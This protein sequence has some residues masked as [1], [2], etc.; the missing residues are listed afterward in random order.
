MTTVGAGI[1]GGV[2]G[3]AAQAVS[4]WV[5]GIITDKKMVNAA[6]KAGIKEQDINYMKKLDPDKKRLMAEYL[7]TAETKAQN[8]Y[9]PDVLLPS[10]KA[11]EQTT[12]VARELA[13]KMDEVG[14]QIGAAKEGTL[15]ATGLDKKVVKTVA[16][17]KQDYLD[18]LAAKYRI[19]IDE[20]GL[21]NF[22]KSKFKNSLGDQRVLQQTLNELD[23]IQNMGDLLVA[24]DTI[25]SDIYSTRVKDALTGS[26]GSAEVVRSKLSN[27][28]PKELKELDNMFAELKPL[29]GDIERTTG[30]T[31]QFLKS[32]ARRSGEMITGTNMWNL[33]RRAL[34][35]GNQQYL[36]LLQSMEKLGQKYGVEGAENLYD[37]IVMANISENLFKLES[38]AKPTGTA[39]ILGAATNLWKGNPAQA[40]KSLGSM[41]TNTQS[42]A[43][44]AETLLKDP[45]INAEIMK[46]IFSNEVIQQLGGQAKA[47]A[48]QAL[49]R[50]ILDFFTQ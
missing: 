2:T 10:E 37:N 25:S 32:G 17:I 35:T 3:A 21:L 38:Q 28:L 19:T 15:S 22:S 13:D 41:I 20:D 7:K 36:K 45:A 6:K 5:N 14:A 16:N 39:A 46:K 8:A 18:D 40:A 48:P 1:V 43:E 49:T 26:E 4:N 42:A 23:N 50:E 33:N 31:S 47:S 44:A 11:A 30:G 9:N 27:V 34:G 29:L 24:K 12:R